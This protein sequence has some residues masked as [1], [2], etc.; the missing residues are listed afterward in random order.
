MPTKPFA[1]FD[2]I[3]YMRD[4]ERGVVWEEAII[5]LP[6]NIRIVFLSATLSNAHEFC[7]WVAKLKQRYVVQRRVT[8]FRVA[9]LRSATLC[10]VISCWFC[11]RF[12]F[13]ELCSATPCDIIIS[14]CA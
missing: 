12:G 9:S 1:V 4:R 5:L 3:H 2:E 7:D 13:V 8:L 6:P 14:C 11:C 10:D